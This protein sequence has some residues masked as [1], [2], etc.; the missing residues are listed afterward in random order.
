MEMFDANLIQQ[1]VRFKRTAMEKALGLNVVSG[2]QIYLINEIEE[3]VR[4]DA[5]LRGGKYTILI[6]KSTQSIVNFDDNF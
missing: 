3:D 1:V 4:F 2:Q 5:S 6:N